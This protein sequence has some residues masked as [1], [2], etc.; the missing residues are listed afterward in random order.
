[1]ICKYKVFV[2]NKGQFITKNVTNKGLFESICVTNKGLFITH[3][4]VLSKLIA[5]KG[6]QNTLFV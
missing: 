2:T 4:R 3:S 6:S 1:M 5:K